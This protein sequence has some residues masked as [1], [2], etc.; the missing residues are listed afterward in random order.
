MSKVNIFRGL[1]FSGSREAH[2]IEIGSY[3]G[4]ISHWWLMDTF[5][6]RE[7]KVFF[8]RLWSVY[9]LE[10][11]SESSFL[12]FASFVRKEFLSFIW[13]GSTFFTNHTSTK[14]HILPH[15]ASIKKQQ[16]RKEREEG[17]KE[18]SHITDSLLRQSSCCIRQLY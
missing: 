6:H 9:L 5:H 12:M 14:Q 15:T 17:K 16:S 4:I 7:I 8:I 18:T 3:L 1:T 10:V 13:E 11:L 2:K